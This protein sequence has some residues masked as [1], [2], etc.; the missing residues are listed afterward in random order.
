MAKT[1][2]ITAGGNTSISADAY[3]HISGY[4]SLFAIV[5][6]TQSQVTFE[7]GGTLSKLA[8]NV[9]GSSTGVCD[10]RLRINGV[11]GNQIVSYASGETGIK[12]DLVNTDSV[13]AGDEINLFEDFISGTSITISN[14]QVVFDSSVNTY[15]TLISGST[16]QGQNDA[17]TR[18]YHFAQLTAQGIETD[19]QCEMLTGGTFKHFFV[20]VTANTHT[21]ANSTFR[22]RINTA[23][24]GSI[25]VVYAAAETGFKEDTVNTASV[26][27]SNLC[28]FSLVT[29]ANAG[30]TTITFSTISIG[31]ETTNS[32]YQETVIIFSMAM[33]FNLTWYEV[34]NGKPIGFNTTETTRQTTSRT[35]N[36]DLKE[37]STEVTANTITTSPTTIDYR[38][39]AGGN[40]LQISYAAAET[41]TK[42]VTGTIAIIDG[43]KINYRMITPNTSGSITFQQVSSLYTPT[44]IIERLVITRP[45][46]MLRI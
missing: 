45:K 30:T 21:T 40:Y 28:D 19:A 2:L 26:A 37:L 20:N 31:F 5:T 3:S 16:P 38:V 17:F 43:D 42:S 39:N 7:Q 9:T 4:H 41:G 29:D 44:A 14:T 25:N 32:Q 36:T 18:F 33:S 8:I 15:Q 23:D 24:A 10:I 1:K 35:G 11:N 46:R 12:E 34:I 13:T 27:D 6:E 22:P